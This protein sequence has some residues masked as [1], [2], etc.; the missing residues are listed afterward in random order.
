MKNTKKQKK[1]TKKEKKDIKVLTVVFTLLLVLVIVLGVL[2]YKKNEEF[3]RKAFANITIPILKTDS[4]EE[5]SINAK[6]LSEAKKYT[7]KITNYQGDI[8]NKEEIDYKIEITNNT[9]AVITIKREDT[10][11]LMNDQKNTIIDGLRLGK[12]AKEDIY[13]YVEIKTFKKLKTND[14]INIKIV[15]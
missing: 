14:L 15:S 12:T 4:E 1:K 3:K 8:I 2:C 11:D 10:K 9:N 13:Y 6:T 7:F 5:F